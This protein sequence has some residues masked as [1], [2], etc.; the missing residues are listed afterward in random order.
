MLTLTD[1]GHVPMTDD[2][3]QVSQVILAGSAGGA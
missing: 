2:P 3:E 1:C